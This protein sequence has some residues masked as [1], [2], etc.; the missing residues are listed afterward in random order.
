MTISAI[1]AFVQSVH[2]AHNFDEVPPS[3][4][5]ADSFDEAQKR[6]KMQTVI[7]D[8]TERLSATKD[9]AFR[10]ILQEI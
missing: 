7:D 10:K 2:C 5:H 6:S 1:E 3:E 9:E 8:F 4:G